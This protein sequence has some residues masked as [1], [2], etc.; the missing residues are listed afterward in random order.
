MDTT[1][2]MLEPAQEVS[3]EAAKIEFAPYLNLHQRAGW[4]FIEV[5]R[6]SPLSP[7]GRQ[8]DKSV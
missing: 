2:V 4:D 1:P 5:R 3:A 7:E 8:H 6:E